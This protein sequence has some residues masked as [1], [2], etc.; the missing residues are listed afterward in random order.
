MNKTLKIVLIVVGVVVV[1]LIVVIVLLK[2]ISS[3]LS[4]NSANSAEIKSADAS[5]KSNMDNIL[6]QSENYHDAHGD[7]GKSISTCKTGVFSDPIITD[8]LN[9]AIISSAKDASA[10]CSTDTSGQR[11][12]II[13]GPLKSSSV[14]YW[15]I[16]N[17]GNRK[18]VT[19]TTF[20]TAGACP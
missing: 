18:A 19:A 3:S 6:A 14:N 10:H 11:L 17:S 16:D 20:S 12:A 9:K 8:Q 5:V 15:C 7:Y 2:T 1:L 13:V 4:V